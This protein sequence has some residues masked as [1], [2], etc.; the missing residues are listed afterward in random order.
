MKREPRP[1]YH[2]HNC[3]SP[4]P[5]LSPRPYSSMLHILLKEEE[6]PKHSLQMSWLSFWLQTETRQQHY[7]LMQAERQWRGNISLTG[8]QYAWSATSCVRRSG[9]RWEH[10]FPIIDQ[11]PKQ[12]IWGP[13][14]KRQWEIRRSRVKA[15]GWTYGSGHKIWTFSHAST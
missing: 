9:P 6:K 5:Q 13:E 15:C 2:P 11:W 10:R 7:S 8:K 4:L 12:L 3:T 14:G 1:P